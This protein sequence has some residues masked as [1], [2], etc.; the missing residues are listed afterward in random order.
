[1]KKDEE[2]GEHKYEIQWFCSNT[3][4]VGMRAENG[5][6]FFMTLFTFVTLV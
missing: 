6:Q 3:K 5:R 2:M 4:K 1:M